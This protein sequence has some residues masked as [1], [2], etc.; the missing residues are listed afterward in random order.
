MQDVWNTAKGWFG[1]APEQKIGKDLGRYLGQLGSEYIPIPGVNGSQFGEWVGSFLPFKNGGIVPRS[2]SNVREQM[3]SEGFKGYAEGGPV[4]SSWGMEVLK[5]L[6]V[7]DG[8]IK[9]GFIDDNMKRFF[10]GLLGYM[11]G[12]VVGQIVNPPWPQQLTPAQAALR[13]PF[14]TPGVV[15]KPIKF[16]AK[17]K[18]TKK[19][20]EF[21]DRRMQKKQVG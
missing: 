3:L 1:Y 4:E 7:E 13:K 21:L 8:K 5:S 2:V 11:N 10:P 15:M 20:K 19:G 17:T 14:P 12:G 16:K 6:R 9:S 18:I